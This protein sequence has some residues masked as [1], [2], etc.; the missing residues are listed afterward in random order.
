MGNCLNRI[1]R[2]FYERTG[3]TFANKEAFF[4]IKL[5]QI[6][7]EALI[8]SCEEF[9]E[10][11]KSDGTLFAKMIEEL[12]ISQSFFFRESAHFDILLQLIQSEAKI[13]PSILS[14]PCANGEEPYSIA[15]ALLQNGFTT[16]SID[17]ADISPKAIEKARRG[18]YEA[19]MLGNLDEEV[20]KR[21]FI[22]TD[23]DYEVRS[24]LKSYINFHLINLF[25]ESIAKLEEYD[26]IFCRNLF[27]Y[28][29][30]SKKSQALQIF[31]NLLKRDGYLF[32]SFSDYLKNH[33]GFDKIAIDNKIFYKKI[34][35]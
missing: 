19:R 4:Y 22:Y 13:A 7:K 27:I 11:M 24:E 6:M 1:E 12:T 26:F 20:K 16:F 15:I 14:L 3:I 9:L 10:R 30:E 21:F 18:R 25:D 28:L 23:G 2:L 29:D 34:E 33:E 8:F 31:Y 5:T 17:A 32:L 35:I